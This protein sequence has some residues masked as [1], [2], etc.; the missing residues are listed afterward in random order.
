MR[1]R[2]VS[3]I[4]AAVAVV[5]VTLTAAVSPVPPADP[6]VSLPALTS[7]A[8]SVRYAASA[9]AAARAVP[10]GRPVR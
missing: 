5:A 9:R 6:P 10:G 4:A 8:L 2:R 3:A 1:L 7:H